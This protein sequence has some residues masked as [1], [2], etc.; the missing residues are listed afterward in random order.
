MV[1]C[2]TSQELSVCSVSILDVI[3]HHA[4]LFK[5]AWKAPSFLPQQW[6]VFLWVR[7]FNK[8]NPES[9]YMKLWVRFLEQLPALTSTY[10]QPRSRNLV[11]AGILLQ[12][13]ASF[14]Q[15]WCYQL[16]YVQTGQQVNKCRWTSSKINTTD[17]F[18]FFNGNTC[19]F[20]V[21]LSIP[22]LTFAYM[23]T[24]A[25]DAHWLS[26][27]LNEAQW[28]WSDASWYHLSSQGV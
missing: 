11:S 9:C 27:L 13:F 6:F 19:T 7:C 22:G 4:F 10:V 12:G 17:D 2:W 14:L 25:A 15:M 18:F 1:A 3:R 5:C 8:I 28:G 16:L 24:Y 21:S 26:V 20:Q 23:Q